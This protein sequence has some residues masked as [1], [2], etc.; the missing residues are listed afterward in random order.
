MERPDRRVEKR[1]VVVPERDRLL[2]QVQGWFDALPEGAA[3]ISIG[4][5]QEQDATTIEIQPHNPASADI[6]LMLY[7]SVGLFYVQTGRYFSLDDVTDSADRTTFTLPLIELCQ[8]IAEGRIREIEYLWKG[9]VVG[10]VTEI[11][12]ASGPRIDDWSGL[13]GGLLR[14]WRWLRGGKE[15]RITQY[16]PY[17][18]LQR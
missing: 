5:S 8:A 6:Y 1:I 7:K 15:E 14:V 18:E 10:C 12:L 11:D 13:S 3:R 17:S 9:R 2:R 16:A 4:D